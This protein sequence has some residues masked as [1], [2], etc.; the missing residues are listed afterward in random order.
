MAKQPDARPASCRALVAELEGGARPAPERA[1]PA[2][3]APAGH[4][5]GPRPG[6]DGHRRRGDPRS[7]RGRDRPRRRRP[8]RWC[9][10]TRRRTRSPGAMTLGPD[11]GPVAAAAGHV[12]VISRREGQLWQVEPVSGEVRRPGGP[13]APQGPRGARR[14][15]LRG[16]RRRRLRPRRPHARMTRPPGSGARAS[17][18]HECSIAAGPGFGIAASGVP[19][20]AAHRGPR[21]APDESSGRPSHPIP[22]AAHHGAPAAAAS[23]A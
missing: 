14:H 9:G 11:P 2:A 22:G 21:R 20:R 23:A 18:L 4:R 8:D 17:R 5:H 6:G 16:Q 13:G 1:R 19:V 3:P 7:P 10:S 15:D 12:W